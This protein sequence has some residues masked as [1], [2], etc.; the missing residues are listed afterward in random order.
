MRYALGTVLADATLTA[1]TDN[2]FVVKA[3]AAAPAAGAAEDPAQAAATAAATPQANRLDPTLAQR[4]GLRP[5]G[6]TAPGARPPAAPAPNPSSAA[7]ASAIPKLDFSAE[8][9][10]KR[11]G[12][13]YEL[14]SKGKAGEQTV[15]AMVTDKGRLMVPV[16]QAK[17]TLFFVRKI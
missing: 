15:E 5:G 8:G 6:R 10:W 3:N 16:P 4:Y 12:D 1:Y 2:R 7:V 17:F 14:L 9:T 13:K 11:V